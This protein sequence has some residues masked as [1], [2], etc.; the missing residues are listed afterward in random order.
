MSSRPR[1][2]AADVHPSTRRARVS[3]VGHAMEPRLH[4]LGA[5]AA[6]SRAMGPRL[7]VFRA[8]EASS[9]GAFARRGLGCTSPGSG[10]SPRPSSPT[11]FRRHLP[12]SLAGSDVF[13]PTTP[14]LPTTPAGPPRSLPGNHA[15]RPTT[16]S[17]PTTP[18]GSPL[19]A[20]TQGGDVHP[21]A[22]GA[23][24]R[25]SST[26]WGPACTPSVNP[27][28]DRMRRG[29]ACTSSVH[30]MPHRGA[31]V[32]DEA[33]DEHRDARIR[34]STKVTRDRWDASVRGR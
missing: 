6:S 16:P 10:P 22:R 9:W 32:R 25:R 18:A 1:R 14:S 31:S 26:R 8:S 17:L 24:S 4:V 13:R 12:P 15:F 5:S 7:H 23:R 2:R 19:G 21:S 11:I 34:R 27:R 3:E 33:P 20:P 30:P 29:R 28:P